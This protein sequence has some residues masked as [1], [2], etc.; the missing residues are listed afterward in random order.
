MGD[1][2]EKQT[3][4]EKLRSPEPPPDEELCRCLDMPPIKLMHVLTENPIHCMNCNL[5]VPAETL[6]LPQ[7]LVEEMS[8]WNKIYHAIYVLWLDSGA[9][10][11]WAREQLTHITSTVNTRGRDVKR[12]LHEICRCYYWYFQDQSADGYCPLRSCP[13]CGD[14]LQDYTAGIFLQR[15]CERDMIVLVGE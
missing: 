3:R 14:P 13:V 10:E 2:M 1:T 15:V 6:A 9:Y 8:Y 4:Y 5:E 11:A 12:N 7:R